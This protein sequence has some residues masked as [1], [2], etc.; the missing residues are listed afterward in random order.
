M[1]ILVDEDFK[2]NIKRSIIIKEM[3]KYD[4]I[5][6]RIIKNNNKYEIYAKKNGSLKDPNM[7]YSFDTYKT[8]KKSIKCKNKRKIVDSDEELNLN[9][10][11][12]KI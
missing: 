12:L 10:K 2:K 3:K 8:K 11:K 9:L 6:Y 5:E 7:I 1:T 4:I